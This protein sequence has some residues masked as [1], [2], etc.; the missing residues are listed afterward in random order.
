MAPK[1]DLIFGDIAIRSRLVTEERVAECIKIQQSLKEW[2]PLGVVLMEKGYITLVQ[3]QTLVDI[4]K[5]NIEAKA[6]R[7]RRLKEDNIFGKIA[8]RL[9]FTSEKQVDECL[10]VQLEMADDYPLRLGEIMVKKGFLTEEQVKKIS[11]FQGKR[12][13]T[14][15]K[16]GQNYNVILFNP[17]AKFICY[18]CDKE[19]TTNQ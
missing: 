13:I 6:I 1:E 16:C 12:L 17:G 2:K 3:L 18:A 10:G 11:E 7:A 19:L 5:R 4:Q 8:L 14:C 15:P 9:G